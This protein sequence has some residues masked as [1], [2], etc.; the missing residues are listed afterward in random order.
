MDAQR[1]IP[2]VDLAMAR[3]HAGCIERLAH[4]G[5][6]LEHHAYGV[7]RPGQRIDDLNA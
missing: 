2:D 3:E 6:V 4:G 5:T 1:L 7:E